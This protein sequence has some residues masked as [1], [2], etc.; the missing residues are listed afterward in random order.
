MVKKIWLVCIGLLL[1]GATVFL[2]FSQNRTY[3]DCAACVLWEGKVICDKG[4]NQ[5][6]FENSHYAKVEAKKI[7]C[8]K[9]HNA[10]MGACFSLDEDKFRFSCSPKVKRELPT[11]FSVH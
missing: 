8:Y 6:I 5:W 2:L 3:Y 9:I 11:I 4:P 7:L 10:P 1:L